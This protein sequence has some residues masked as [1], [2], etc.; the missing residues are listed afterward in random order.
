MLFYGLFMDFPP[1]L[2]VVPLPK[3]LISVIKVGSGTFSLNGSLF[4]H[5]ITRGRLFFYH[6]IT[7]GGLFDQKRGKWKQRG[8]VAVQALFEKDWVLAYYY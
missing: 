8:L 4:Y 1:W 3:M 6:L 2:I 5:L 7:R